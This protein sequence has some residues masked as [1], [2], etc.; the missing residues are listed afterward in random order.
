MLIALASILYGSV[1]A[2]TVTDTRLILGYSSVAQL[3]FITLGI[4]SL[5]DQGAQGGILQAVNHGLV[6]VPAFFI[7][8]LLAARAHGSEDLRD[9][10]GLALRRRSWRRCS[11]SSPW[12]TWPCP[13]RRTSPAS[14]F[15]LLG[16][17]TASSSSA[18][19][20]R[21]ASRWPRSTRCGS[22]S[23]RCTTAS[24]PAPS[25]AR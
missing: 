7:L 3:G 6:V 20:P 14:S 12:P 21:R 4:F 9:L 22:S 19:W 2:F 17:S 8:A 23:A 10:G 16:S 11:S 1:L 13:A 18:S 24:G 25:R 5:T 15:I